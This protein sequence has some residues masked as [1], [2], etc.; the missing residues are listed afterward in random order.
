MEK[1]YIIG[2]NPL[3]EALD[4][5]KEIQRIL[6][7]R[8]LRNPEIL[9]AIKEAKALGIPCSAVPEQKLARITKKNHQGIIAFLSPITFEVL[10]VFIS[11]LYESAL[12][13]KVLLLDGITDVR[14]FGAVVRSAECLGFHTVVIPS[15]GMA[16]INADAIKSSSGALLRLPICRTDNV[17]ECITYLQSYGIKV[18]GCTEK[19]DQ[20]INETPLKGAI[21]VVLGNEETGLSRASLTKADDLVRIPMSGQVQS[22]NVAASG[23]IAMYEVERQRLASE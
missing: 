9:Q 8:G 23:A 13:P 16:P 10:D 14:N 15:K 18:I 17:A 21:C 5:E 20:L 4:K 3:R 11:Q 22:L 12:V 6:Y 19:S 1:D 2:H 7:L